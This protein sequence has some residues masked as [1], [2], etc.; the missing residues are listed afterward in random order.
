MRK[1]TATQIAAMTASL[2]VLGN[3]AT[4]YGIPMVGLA[5]IAH[6]DVYNDDELD[7]VIFIVDGTEFPWIVRAYPHTGSGCS[8]T[9]CT[10]TQP[11]VAT[12][13][14]NPTLPVQ[15]NAMRCA[16]RY[17]IDLTVRFSHLDNG[18]QRSGFNTKFVKG[19][20]YG[21]NTTSQADD[22]AV[23]QTQD[24]HHSKHVLG[25]TQFD[26]VNTSFIY[27]DEVQRDATAR[28]I[29]FEENLINTIVHE[30]SHAHWSPETE[31]DAI[32]IGNAAGDAYRSDGG[33]NASCNTAPQHNGRVGGG[34]N[35]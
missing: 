8:G 9:S 21:A 7:E 29:D 12:A 26:G 34:G 18:G 33:A 30:W 24:S 10:P 27:I 16:M 11:P 3:L 32:T 20:W 22:P 23:S 6:A 5:A 14:A 25:H 28:G 19:Y 1:L 4:R 17:S 15:R 35:K 31:D 2:G 13:P